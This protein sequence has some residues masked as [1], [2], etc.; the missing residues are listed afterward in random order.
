MAS[1]PP[2]CSG[3]MS[4]P[5]S[6]DRSKPPRRI[7][8]ARSARVSW[9]YC[10]P[11]GLA[12]STNGTLSVPSVN[13]SNQPSAV[14]VRLGSVASSTRALL[15]VRSSCRRARAVSEGAPRRHWSGSL[16]PSGPVSPAASARS[17][18]DHAARRRSA[19]ISSGATPV[20]AI[21]TPLPPSGAAARSGGSSASCV[22]PV[23][24]V[25]SSRRV[26]SGG[27]SLSTAFP[28]SGG[29]CAEV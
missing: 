19:P 11:P 2:V 18:S 9:L 4:T 17:A 25:S 3:A 15:A 5:A 21:G 26:A 10:T 28:F 1:G 8:S 20:G 12:G 6:R 24:G 23:A 27:A 16:G 13:D 29:G 7:C 22:A 14:I